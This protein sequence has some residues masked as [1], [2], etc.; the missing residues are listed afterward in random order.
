MIPT[1]LD[2]PQRKVIDPDTALV[3]QTEHL[4]KR[5]GDF[6][7]LDD[8]SLHVRRGEIY[9]F[10][11]PNGAGKTTTMLLLL[12]QL[13]PT[14]GRISLFGR[15]L[16]RRDPLLFTRIGVVG[17]EQY[18]YDEMTAGEYLALFADL[19]NV[20]CKGL[21]E[22]RLEEVGLGPQRDRRIATFSHGMRQRL[23]LA[24]ALL[25]DPE[26]L[27]LDE[28]VN[29]LD[30]H[31]IR[32]I[33]E[34]LLDLKR[35]GT[36]IFISSHILSEVERLADRVGILYRGRLLAEGPMEALGDAV[37]GRATLEIEVT[38]VPA[39][40][41]DRLRALPFVFDVEACP[42]RLTVDVEREGDY[43][44]QVS[45]TL[46]GLGAVIVGMKVRQPSLEETF[47]TLTERDLAGLADRVRS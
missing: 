1:A 41:V 12:G 2:L 13:R 14:A 36:T 23:A 20:R 25:H 39:E 40:A 45:Q 38:S 8:V 10:L 34:R 16:E 5:Y 18:L 43:R 28:P 24:R 33:R 6:T 44:A 4:T 19:L 17:E 42:G 37:E 9:G 32:E 11:G 21:V 7:A 46:T 22:A 3:L 29:G 47:M 15:P 26:L 35:R 27:F 31:G 30:P